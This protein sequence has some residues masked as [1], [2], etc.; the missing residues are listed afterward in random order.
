M[1]G[2]YECTELQSAEKGD[3]EWVVGTDGGVGCG[4]G[5][6]DWVWACMFWRVWGWWLGGEGWGKWCGC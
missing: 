6:G 5:G 1:L 4:F 3:K 2:L